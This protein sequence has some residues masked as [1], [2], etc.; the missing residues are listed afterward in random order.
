MRTWKQKNHLFHIPRCR[1]YMAHGI[2]IIAYSFETLK[3]NSSI[4]EAV[5]H[6]NDIKIPFKDNPFLK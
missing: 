4:I 3:E 2:K 5:E 1:I 6:V